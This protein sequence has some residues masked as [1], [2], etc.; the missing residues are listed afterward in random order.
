[1]NH[2]WPGNLR[3]LQNLIR[4]LYVFA[5]GPVGVDQ[6]HFQERPMAGTSSLLLSDAEKGHI[7]KVLDLKK[8]NQRQTALAL[9]VVDDML[10]KKINDYGLE[11]LVARCMQAEQP[12]HAALRLVT[13]RR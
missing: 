7:A 9:G 1:M 5:E 11:E 8:G 12:D 6:L 13:C 2:T 4:R 10:K 3:E